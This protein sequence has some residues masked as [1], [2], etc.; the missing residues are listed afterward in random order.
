MFTTVTIT[1]EPA[2]DYPTLPHHKLPTGYY[3][4]RYQDESIIV[5]VFRTYHMFCDMWWNDLLSYT[6]G[7]DFSGWLRYSHLPD[8]ARVTWGRPGWVRDIYTFYHRGRYGWAPRDTWNLDH[9]L[10]R[11]LGCTLQHLAEKTR[12]TPAGY[13]YRKNPPMDANGPKTD[14]EQWEKDLWRWSGAFRDLHAWE[15]HEEMEAYDTY[16]GHPNGFKK[17]HKM[18]QKRHR[19]VQKALKEL[20]PWWSCL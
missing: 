20:A 8:V 2:R 3:R 12:G 17:I 4:V 16:R 9:Y 1:P 5:L 11:V 19:R 18:E 10:N 7:I 6:L 15:D 14:H 13:P